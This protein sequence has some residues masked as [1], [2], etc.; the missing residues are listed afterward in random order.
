MT[1]TPP[2]SHPAPELVERVA[3]A[4]ENDLTRQAEVQHAAY[5][6]EDECGVASAC[7]N[8]VLAEVA[9]A[10]IAAL[11]DNPARAERRKIVDWLR[12]QIRIGED[13]VLLA[14]EGSRRERDLAAGVIALT[15]A[16]DAIEREH[17]APGKAEGGR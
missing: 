1:A 12:G 11:S 5:M 4:I 13:A 15:K 6:P 14:A 9:R 8:I 17:H 10:A 16:A 7:M 3:R 2:P